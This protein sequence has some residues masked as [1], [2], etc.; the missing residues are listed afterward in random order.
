MKMK[1]MNGF[2]HLFAL[3]SHSV[4]VIAISKS[5]E[6]L[7]LVIASHRV[8]FSSCS[9]HRRLLRPPLLPL[10]QRGHSDWSRLR[11][12]FWQVRFLE[13]LRDEELLS[14]GDTSI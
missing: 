4:H 6:R 10:L 14:T 1:D 13:V 12:L 2:L 9:S 8:H 11:G 5:L 3:D 7:A